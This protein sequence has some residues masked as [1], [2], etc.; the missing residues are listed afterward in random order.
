MSVQL[1]DKVESLDEDGLLRLVDEAPTQRRGH[2][3]RVHWRELGR[4]ALE[5]AH[6]SVGE[7]PGCELRAGHKLVW[8]ACVGGRRAYGERGP[9]LV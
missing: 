1:V 4:V 8:R 6:L 3:A 5:D 7:L 9:D 2:Y